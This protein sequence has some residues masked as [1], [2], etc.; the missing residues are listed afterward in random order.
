MLDRS[1]INNYLD[2]MENI[3]G[4]SAN[5][6]T[7]YKIDLNLLFD[8]L[9]ENVKKSI[10]EIELQD[11]HDFLTY[12]SNKI[13]E[14]TKKKGDAKSTRARRVASIR[15]FFRYLKGIIKLIDINPAQELESPKIERKNPKYLNLQESES[16]L[17][18]IDG[19]NK[20]RD[21]AIITVFLNCALRLS[22]LININVDDIKDD[23][24]V[25]MG[26]GSKE[27]TIYL[28]ET[29]LEVIED[30]L[31]VR[32]T[33]AKTNALFISSRWN[34]ISVSAVQNLI[35]KH[36]G[37]AGLDTDALGV[38]SLRHSSATLMYKYGDVDIRALQELLG[39]KNISTTQIY[40]HV[41]NETL[42]NAVK[43]NPLNKAK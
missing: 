35:K 22:E 42:R 19:R 28:N 3:R 24:L 21:L 40:T 6:I 11:L 9:D 23:I 4:K 32:P 31:K 20:E 38:H 18:V 25:V 12:R 17:S 2:Y 33:K 29:T 36:L 7:G 15:S 27:R 14:K 43:S 8:F 34:R 5:T 37:I 16:L 13:N 1:L 41:D 26:K 30:Y 39:H 10:D